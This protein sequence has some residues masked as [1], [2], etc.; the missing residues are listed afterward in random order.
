M[1]IPPAMPTKHITEIRSF[2]DFMRAASRVLF[3]PLAEVIGTRTALGKLKH[4][5]T[6]LTAALDQAVFGLF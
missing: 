6:R 2:F 1:V 3:I 4:L 5:S